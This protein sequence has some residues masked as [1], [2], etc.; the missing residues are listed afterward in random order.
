VE[1]EGSPHP[2][3][4]DGLSKLGHLPSRPGEFEKNPVDEGLP[5]GMLIKRVL[6]TR[7]FLDKLRNRIVHT[8]RKLNRTTRGR[9]QTREHF[10]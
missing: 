8:D 4:Q 6:A 1:L 2:E 9:E 5:K 3:V 10:D 7:G